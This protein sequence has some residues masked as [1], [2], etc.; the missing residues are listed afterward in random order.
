M[1]CISRMKAPPPKKKNTAFKCISY[2]DEQTTNYSPE[3]QNEKRK[4]IVSK[5]AL[6]TCHQRRDHSKEEERK[7]FLRARA[8]RCNHKHKHRA[9][10]KQRDIDSTHQH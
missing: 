8:C 6:V 4:N 10:L 2:N 7:Y 3:C 9:V 1:K 5:R